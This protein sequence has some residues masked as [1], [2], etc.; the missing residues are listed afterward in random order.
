MIKDNDRIS[1]W[2]V[3]IIIISTINAVEILSSPRRLVTFAGPDGW[4][5]VIGG[6]LLG[7]LGLFFIIKLGL[8]YP[9]DTLVEYSQKIVGR[10]FGSLVA[11]LAIL[12]WLLTTAKTTRQFAEFT[13]LILHETPIEVII[14]SLLVVVAYIARHGLEPIARMLEILF[15]IFIA[16]LALLFFSAAPKGDYTNLLPFLNTDVKSLIHGTIDNSLGMEGQESLVMLLPFMMASKD[17]YKAGFAAIGLDM[18][19]RIAAF[20]VVI[21]VLG[22]HLT[23]VF[24]WPLE[25]IGRFLFSPGEF[26]GRLD[27][28]FTAL[29][30]TVAFSAVLVYYY[31]VSLTLSRLLKFRE[32]TPLVFPLLPVIFI[33]SLIPSNV[34]EVER[35]S[36]MISWVFGILAF[37]VPPLLLLISYIRGTHKKSGKDVGT[38]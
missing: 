4:L 10:F 27:A 19:L 17:A 20:I 5:L 28:F 1:S 25:E 8:L 9:K 12:F 33:L 38:G 30:V 13:H 2:Q 24:L 21:A 15:P 31:L 3:F 11:V 23:K 35:A 7:A 29:W 36:S 26:F 18:L 22:E 32:H 14:I 16:I 34:F 37:T 6:H